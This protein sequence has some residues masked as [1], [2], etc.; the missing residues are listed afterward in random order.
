[1]VNICVS[2]C[3]K[4]TVKIWFKRYKMIHLCGALTMD[5]ACRTGSCSGWVNDWAVR[6]CDVLKHY[7]TLL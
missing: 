1:M 2:K 4:G 3:R 6:K 7:C 5:G